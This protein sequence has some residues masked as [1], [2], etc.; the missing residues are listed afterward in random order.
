MSD[1]HGDGSNRLTLRDL[2]ADNGYRL[3]GWRVRF[4]LGPVRTI[5]TEKA[6]YENDWPRQVRSSPASVYSVY[7]L[8][9]PRVINRFQEPIVPATEEQ[10]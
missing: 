9:L 2:A 7:F 3:A 6:F 8:C 1:R 5:E 4:C 10:V